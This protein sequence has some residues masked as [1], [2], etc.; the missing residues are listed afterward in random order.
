MKL[1]IFRHVRAYQSLTLK[2]SYS[3]E[4]INSMALR[5]TSN[6]LIMAYPPGKAI[7]IFSQNKDRKQWSH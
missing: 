4:G 2:Q 3:P 1:I 7:Q 5:I 6:H